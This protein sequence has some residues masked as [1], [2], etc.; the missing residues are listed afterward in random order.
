MFLINVIVSHNFPNLKIFIDDISCSCMKNKSFK[1]RTENN[2]LRIEYLFDF[3]AKDKIKVDK[4][5]FEK[6]CREGCVN[7]NK[8]YSCPPF[9][10]SFNI[11]CRDFEGLFVVMFVCRLNQISSTEYNKIRIANVI[12][13]SRI[14][15]LM[16]EL[17]EKTN[18]KYLSTGSCRLCK[19]CKLKLKQP[20]KHPNKRR[21]SLESTGIDCNTLV[22]KL[23]KIK[24]QWYRDKKA[25]EYTC[26]ACGLICNKGD[27]KN[28]EK[29]ILELI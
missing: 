4:L 12:M 25:P 11:L 21:Y 27:V 23:F 6:M 24:L 15:K 2:S 20:C 26:V 5:L 9:S 29:N 8:K 7:Y 28:I 17:E 14:D 3:I 1:I 22:E 16:R 10:P 18:L 19:P 13:K